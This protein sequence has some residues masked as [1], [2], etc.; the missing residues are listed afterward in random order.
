V[1]F[2]LPLCRSRLADLGYKAIPYVADG[3]LFITDNGNH[4]LD[5]EIEPLAG[6][7]HFL[8]EAILSIPGVVDTGLFL[9]MAHL[10]L[11]GDEHFQLVKERPRRT[12]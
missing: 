10:V 5:C 4:I 6:D 3:R 8:E 9:G 7:P 2:G 1:P 11:V 12:T